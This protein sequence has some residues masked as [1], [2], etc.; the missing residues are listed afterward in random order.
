MLHFT[1]RCAL[2]I[3]V[4]AFA[5]VAFAVVA[6]VVVAFVA[7]IVF[8]V[9]LDLLKFPEQADELVA[10]VLVAIQFVWL[11]FPAPQKPDEADSTS[12]ASPHQK[13]QNYDSFH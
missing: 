8:A 1:G 3:V 9:T 12:H 6:F 10:I 7:G 4:V 11:F 5:V 13:D 2:V